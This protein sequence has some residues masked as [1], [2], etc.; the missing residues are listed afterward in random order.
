M[1][2]L[3]T[4]AATG[5]PIKRVSGILGVLQDNRNAAD[6]ERPRVLFSR[7]E[8]LLLIADAREAIELLAAMDEDARRRLAVE[9]LVA[10]AR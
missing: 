5:A 10:K 6:Y 4:G 8:V 3:A 2:S 1:A 7:V 9:L